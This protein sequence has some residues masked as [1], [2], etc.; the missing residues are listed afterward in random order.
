VSNAV[1]A[2][3]ELSIVFPVH[4]E[5]ES[6][7]VLWG[8]VAEFLARIGRP[9]EVIFVD[10]GSTDSTADVI[11]GLVGHDGR[12][13]LLRFAAR[14]GL[15]AAF[16]AGLRA[17]RGATVATMDSD[18]QNDPRDLEV[19]LAH[20][21]PADAAIGTRQVRHDSWLKRVSSRIANAV[22]NNLTGD[23]VA[24]SACSLRVMRRECVDAIPSY[25]GMHRF[26]PTL[27]RTAGYRV[28]EVPVHHR[29]RRFGQSKFGVRN[30]ALRAF[31]DLLVVVWMMRR[32][33][34]YR[35][36]EELGGEPRAADTKEALKR[37]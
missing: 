37:P 26:V 35:V 29:P 7:P 14:A 6:L 18:L 9:A 15:T 20:L 33:L 19:L 27:L 13:R 3:P 23:H 31:V 12:V 11:R 16:L 30:R 32:R 5:A 8:E 2:P 28:V 1:S 34:R 36:C 24:D 17:A 4:N 21:G 10:D 22:R 25:D